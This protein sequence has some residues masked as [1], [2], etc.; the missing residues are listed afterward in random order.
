MDHCTQLVLHPQPV[1]LVVQAMR[2]MIAVYS[3]TQILPA[4][5]PIQKLSPEVVLVTLA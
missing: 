5:V 4:N 2:L 3:L 1:Q